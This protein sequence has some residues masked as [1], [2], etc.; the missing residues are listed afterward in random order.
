LLIL[1]KL[2]EEKKKDAP[3]FFAK[4]VKKNGD[5][6]KISEGVQSEKAVKDLEKANYEVVEVERKEALQKSSGSFYYFHFT[7]DGFSSFRLSGKRTMRAA[8]SLYEKGLI[9]YHRTDSFSLSIQA[10]GKIRDYIKREKGEDYLPESPRI[11]KTKSKVAQEAHE[12]VRPTNVSSKP[13]EGKIGRDEYRLYR[14]IWQ[15][16]VASQMKSA[17]WDQAKINI[18]AASQKIF[19]AFLVE[20]K[21]IKF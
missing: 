9:T 11:Y 21:V 16:A 8:Q 13:E 1:V 2:L 6:F 19:M 20:G 15:R 3:T 12:A 18:Q 14:L 4:L 10:V 5:V 17:I 7:T